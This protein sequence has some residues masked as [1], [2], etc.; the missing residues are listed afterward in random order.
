MHLL[1]RKRTVSMQ[2]RQ[3]METRKSF[4]L[5]AWLSDE[6]LGVGCLSR[7]S[8]SSHSKRLPVEIPF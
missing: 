4:I 6:S 1:I 5:R 8:I 2:Y 7:L 3:Y